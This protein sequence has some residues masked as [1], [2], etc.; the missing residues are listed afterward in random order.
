MILGQRHKFQNAFWRRFRRYRLAVISL[1][2]LTLLFAL[3]MLAP[4]IGHTRG[5]DAN[6]VDLF[7]RLAPPSDRHWMGTDT[8]GRDLFLRL[9]H[10]GQVSLL[11]GVSAAVASGAIGSALGL[12]SGYLGGR[13]DA[14][15]MRFADAVIALPVLPLLIILAAVDTSKLGLPATVA[16]ASW[17]ALYKIVVIIAL[18]SWPSVARLVRAAT[19]T[20]RERDFVQV[21]KAQ[22]FS[23]RFGSCSATSCRMP[24][25]RCWLPRL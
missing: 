19:L 7:S 22:G 25:R 24:P 16:G 23:P 9:L 20:I 3:A 17:F 2:I 14:F 13:V 6:A 5:I 8:L 15:V 10:G 18:V 4:V 21:A 12:A 11:V 1:G